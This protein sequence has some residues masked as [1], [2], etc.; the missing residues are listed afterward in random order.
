MRGFL[1]AIRRSARSCA[2]ARLG[3]SL[4]L[5]LSL[6]G[7]HWWVLQSIAWSGMIVSYSAKSGLLQGVEE[8]FDGEHPCPMCKAIKQARESESSP[9]DSLAPVQKSALL[10]GLPP[11]AVPLPTH[12]AFP[13]VTQLAA[14]ASLINLPPPLP[15]PRAA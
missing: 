9:A 11:Q 2:W 5:L 7:A 6:S 8:T 4:L 3:V 15:P 13:Q 1:S 12:A 10:L 14:R